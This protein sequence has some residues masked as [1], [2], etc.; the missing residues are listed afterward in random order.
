MDVKQA[1]ALAK[2]YVLDLFAEEKITNLGLE[3]VEFDEQ[4]KEWIVTLGFSRP[5]DEPRNV[6]AALAQTPYTRRAYKVI[7]ISDV[8]GSVLAVK[9]REENA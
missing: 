2:Q 5:W 1:V 9:A 3:E 6:L 4:T 7:R 8:R